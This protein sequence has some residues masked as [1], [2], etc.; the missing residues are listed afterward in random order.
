MQPLQILQP[1]LVEPVSVTELQ[2]YLKLED[3]TD[4]ARLSALIRTAREA[5]ELFLAQA[6][7]TR[8]IRQRT[9]LMGERFFFAAAPVQSLDA[10]SAF[11]GA[12]ETVLDPAHYTL[13]YSAARTYIDLPNTAIGR[14]VQADYTAGLGPDWNAVPEG[15][16]QGILRLA[17]HQYEHRSDPG[18]AALPHAVTALWQPYRLVRI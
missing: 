11:L 4:G 16:R 7:I 8:Q 3:D 10:L 5:C 1:M 2:T 18:V 6:L 14:T 13:M 15:V 17:A 9:Q 12:D